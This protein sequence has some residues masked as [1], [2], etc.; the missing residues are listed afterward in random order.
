MNETLNSAAAQMTAA[1]ADPAGVPSHPVIFLV[2]GVVTFALHIAAVAVLLGST[3]L[4][5]YA[6]MKGGEMW[7]RL[8]STMAF[9][10]KAATGAAIVLGVAPLL[11][12]QVI[13]DPF[14]YATSMLSAGWTIIF[15]AVLMVAYLALYRVH[16]LLHAEEGAVKNGG[17][18]FWL[19]AALV[20]FLGAGTI[21]HMLA[22]QALFPTHWLTWYAPAGNADASGMQ[23]N[24]VLIPRLLFFFSLALPVTSAWIYGMRRFVLSKA[25]YDNKA[26]GPYSDFLEVV[27]ER[28]ALWGGI[29]VAVTGAAWM[30]ML[31][32]EQAWFLTS[33]WPWLALVAVLFFLAL[34]VIE[35]K[36]RLCVPCNY[37]VFVMVVVMTA[38]LASVREALRVGT[39]LETSAWN[40]LGLT[41]NWDVPTTAIFFVT[42][43]VVGGTALAY[44]L[45]SAWNAGLATSGSKDAVWEPSAKLESLGKWAAGLLGLW[46]A[47]YFVVG[48]AVALA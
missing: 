19:A 36:R 47:G 32:A 25:H 42:F 9:T 3:G 24:G 17:A 26:D 1:L 8:G 44:I 18:V 39:L 2:L 7:D 43:L 31:P 29:L 10:A 16:S 35:K 22:N 41:I 40:P 14:W 37:L 4:A 11:F 5:L 46:I 13:Y 21:M 45:I 33:I 28:M 27:A 34:P 48:A 23:F 15:L 6:R 12:V 30:L 20:L 38:L